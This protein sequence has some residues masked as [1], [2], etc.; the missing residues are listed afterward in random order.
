VFATLLAMGACGLWHGAGWTFAV[1]GLWHGAG[2]V[3][4]RGWKSLKRPL[5]D[6][7]GWTI[8]MAFVI[9]GWV[10]FRAADFHTAVSILGSLAGAEG[11]GGRLQ[12][13]TLILIAALVSML[14]P[15][16]HE[17]KNMRPMPWPSIAVAAAALASYCLLEVGNGPPLN[18][19][20]FQF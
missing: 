5:P 11:S 4:C 15:S 14:V 2:L 1:W 13:P 18:F 17:I 19:I 16:T 7:I 3:A 9:V 10:V 8:T 20:Y 12:A 6:A